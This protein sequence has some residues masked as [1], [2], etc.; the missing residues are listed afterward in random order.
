MRRS[1]VAILLLLTACTGPPPPPP[2]ASPS[3]VPPAT[4]QPERPAVLAGAGDIASCD[5]SGDEAT[6]E[7]LDRIAGTVFT[8]GDNAYDSGSAAEFADCYAPSWGRHKDR[9]RPAP[10]N[11][12]Y[13]TPG[14][15]GYFDYFGAAAGDPD[16]GYYSYGLGSWHV[17][18]VNSNC[19]AVGGCDRGSPQLRWLRDD[20]EA[21]TSECTLA[22]WHHPLFT[23]GAVHEGEVAM[24]PIF[25]ALYEARAELVLTGHNHQYERFA[26][27]DPDGNLDRVRGIRQFVVGTGGRSHYEF[28][29]TQPNSEVRGTGTFGV[30]ELT[31]HRGSFD[32]RFVPVDGQSFTDSGTGTCH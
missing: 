13:A 20:L 8:T 3:P 7:L 17:V 16:R 4:S 23:S 27:Q 24:R 21:S 1:W 32:W 14:A 2:T 9:T 10:G 31:L 25:Q 11:H 29:A 12:E 19:A 5:S 15:A 26:P 30:L 22:Y 18:V 6:A 28:G